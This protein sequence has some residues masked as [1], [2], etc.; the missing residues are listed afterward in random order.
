MRSRL[1]LIAI[2]FALSLCVI[3]VAQQK[4]PTKVRKVPAPYTEPS[5]PEQMYKAYCASC[6]GVEGRGDGPAASALKAPATD[7]TQ[8]SR[9][10]GGEFPAARVNS[11]LSGT[12]ELA[13][14]GSEEM[15]VWGPV[16]RKLGQ[17]NGSHARLRINNLTKYL[18]SMQ[19]R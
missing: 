11:V 3:S 17:D 9:K 1:A 13:A 16:F 15:P 4:T 18:Q 5:A 14:H 2:L 8:L 7:L 6:H 10:N 12:A 19:A